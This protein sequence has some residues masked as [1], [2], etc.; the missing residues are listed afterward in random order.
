M[1]HSRAMFS[2]GMNPIR[3]AWTEQTLS[4]HRRFWTVPDPGE[5]LS[6]PVQAPHPPIRQDAVSSER[7][8]QAAEGGYHLQL[9]TPFTCRT[10]RERWM[11]EL[12]S[13]L[14]EYEAAGR[15]LG[16]HPKPARRMLLVPFFVDPDP[17]RARGIRTE[18]GMV[19]RQGHRQPARRGW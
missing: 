14:A 7:F 4:H 1:E 8:I 16:R 3:R 18:G 13:H 15:R 10:Y 17:A 5:V 12:E 9:A 2:E 11:G 19:L 6:W